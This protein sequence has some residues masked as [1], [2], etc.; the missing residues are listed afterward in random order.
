MLQQVYTYETFFYRRTE[1][2]SCIAW[3]AR[4]SRLACLRQRQKYTA[5]TTG[6]NVSTRVRSKGVARRHVKVHHI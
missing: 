4:D 1:H 6:L 2:G 3:T 5:V